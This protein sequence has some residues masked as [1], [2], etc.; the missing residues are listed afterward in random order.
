[1]QSQYGHHNT[2]SRQDHDESTSTRRVDD[3]TTRQRVNVHMKSCPNEPTYTHNYH[4]MTSR[5]DHNKST[6]TQRVSPRDMERRE[7]R[8]W[9]HVAP[10][11]SFSLIVSLFFSLHLFTAD[12]SSETLSKVA[13]K[14]E[15]IICL[16][17]IIVVQYQYLSKTFVKCKKTRI[18]YPFFFFFLFRKP[19]E[20]TCENPY[21]FA[22][23][24]GFA[25]V[26]IYVPGPVPQGPLPVVFPKKNCLY[27][28]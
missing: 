2:M 11:I 23:G 24:T 4:D 7:D 6:S 10:G 8:E 13:S 17:M 22:E 16:F 14:F 18:R 12:L 26:Q 3:S 20:K 1:M 9:R 27:K 21:P 15:K 28:T 25:R 5:W 19:V